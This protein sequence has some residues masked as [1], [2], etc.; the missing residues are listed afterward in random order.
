MTFVITKGVNTWMSIYYKQGWDFFGDAHNKNDQD[1]KW[2]FKCFK[3]LI[4]QIQI[5]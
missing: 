3:L 1:T 2:D 4:S 5:C